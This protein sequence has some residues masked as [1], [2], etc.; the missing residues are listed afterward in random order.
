MKKSTNLRAF[1]LVETLIMVGI[2]GIIA[3]I[4]I[5]SLKNMRPDKDAV[6]LR[7]AYSETAKAVNTLINDDYLYPTTKLTYNHGGFN[8]NDIY[9]WGLALSSLYSS[10]STSSG[11]DPLSS[12]NSSGGED[13]EEPEPEPHCNPLE[14]EQ[15]LN[16]NRVWDGE[17]C[18]CSCRPADK[19]SC[20]S[21]NLKQFNNENCTCSCKDNDSKKSA[22]EALGK[23][24]SSSNCTCTCK[25]ADK[26]ECLNRTGSWA[27]NN[28]DCIC[29]CDTAA[30]TA[31]NGK[32]TNW[33]WNG[34]N[35]T[36]GCNP[37]KKA[38]CTAK[39]GY[40]WVDST[41]KCRCNQT[42]LSNC[43]KIG[44][45]WDNSNCTC[46]ASDPFPN[47]GI[48]DSGENI[49]GVFNK[50]G[51]PDVSSGRTDGTYVPI[52]ATYI[53]KSDVLGDTTVRG[54][55]YTASNKF[56]YNFGKLFNTTDLSC[57][58]NV[59][60]FTTKDGM[61]WVVTDNF[62]AASAANKKA[63][64]QVNTHVTDNSIYLFEIQKDGRVTISSSN[65]ENIK[66][67]MIRILSSRNLTNRH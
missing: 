44:G 11:D 18:T 3:I 9:L 46:S 50:D 6:M 51:T 14:E 59:C 35:C 31:C 10:S 28:T 30:Q 16:L 29:S 27:W 1:T 58:N 17:E 33:L 32:G 42:N 56:A 48:P 37:E 41:C 60:T 23:Q 4:S 25:P 63:T 36:C 55:G 43:K 57:T 12:D 62:N 38:E 13:E 45:I 40:E 64:V 22:C 20:E 49:N 21:N 24:W 54:T 67:K 15:C 8:L 5:V 7:K 47:Y 34:E 53:P 52:S 19:T 66:N 39:T 61:S 2:V 26:T 65:S